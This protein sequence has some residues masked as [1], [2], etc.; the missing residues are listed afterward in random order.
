M[1]IPWLPKKKIAGAA[2]KLLNEYECIVKDEVQPP[3]PVEKI[4]ERGLKL[5]LEFTDLRAA[6]E[7]DDVLGATYIAQRRICVDKSLLD[8]PSEGRLCFTCAHETGHW[9]LHRKLIDHA[10]R[11]DQPKGFIFCRIKDAQKAV[12]WQ[13]DYFASCLLMPEKSVRRAF[14]KIYGAEPLMIYNLKSSF[15]GPLGIDPCVE[16]WP[17]IAAS[18]KHAGGFSNVSKQAMIIRLQELNL[19]KNETRARLSWEESFALT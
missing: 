5:G 15:C 19:V 16:N 17:L 1:I 2:A 9:V 3:I 10:C 12:E 11:S 4:I 13:A 7:M 8:S 6:L 14:G 18:V